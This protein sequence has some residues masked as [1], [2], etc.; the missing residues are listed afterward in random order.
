LLAPQA[1][2]YKPVFK[3]ENHYMLDVLFHDILPVFSVL[4]LGFILGRNQ[5]VS[6]AEAS[7]LNRIAFLVMQ[8]ALIFAL[9]NRADFKQFHF[10]A[11]L[12]YGLGQLVIFSATFFICFWILKCEKIEA[13]LLAMATIF[14]NALLYI[15]PISQL[16][17]GSGAN[18][19]ITAVVIWDAT[20]IFAFFII[21]TDLLKDQNAS[22]WHTCQRLMKNP[23]LIVIL[24]GIATSIME[25]RAPSAMLTALDFAGRAAAPVT[26]FALGV[27]LSSHSLMPSGVISI[28]SA[29]KLCAL[30]VIVMWAL[31]FGSQPDNWSQLLLLNA[32]GPSGAMAFSLAVLHGIRTDKIAPVI[33]YTSILSLFSLAWLA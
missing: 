25:L 8:P 32:A 23:V 22:V 15:L 14:V 11:I 33:I 5:L 6:T 27:I 10:D 12:L 24:L 3:R 28:I 20:I 18:I 13:W 1:K 17:Y 29:I 4:A 19:P 9:V 26:L 30:P 16:I 21:T 31:R 2:N 7:T